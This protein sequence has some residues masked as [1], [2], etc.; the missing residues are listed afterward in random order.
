M[1]S[2]ASSRPAT[3]GSSPHPHAA[4][5]LVAKAGL[6]CVA[7]GDFHRLEHLGGWKSVVPCARDEE[8]L[9]T[10]LR[11]RRPVFITEVGA[12]TVAIAA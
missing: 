4:L 3:A 10:H 11:S 9:T 8:A 12:E 2:T 6:P 1:R 5:R 7:S